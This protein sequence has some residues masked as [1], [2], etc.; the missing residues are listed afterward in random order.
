MF[1]TWDEGLRGPLCIA[2]PH[3][4]TDAPLAHSPAV[5]PRL[6]LGPTKPIGCRIAAAPSTIAQCPEGFALAVMGHVTLKAA[7]SQFSTVDCKNDSRVRPEGHCTDPPRGGTASFSTRFEEMQPPTACHCQGQGLGCP[8]P[9]HDVSTLYR[10][11]SGCPAQCWQAPPMCVLEHVPG[12]HTPSQEMWSAT[13]LCPPATPFHCPCLLL[14]LPL[15]P[16][17]CECRAWDTPPPLTR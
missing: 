1:P 10:S 16:I 2:P 15:S 13:A 12:G 17:A 3:R 14:L 8:A 6:P 4:A 11:S 9:G 5:V 7:A